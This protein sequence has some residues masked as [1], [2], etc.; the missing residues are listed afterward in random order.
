AAAG[1][2]NPLAGQAA[3]SGGDAGVVA[4]GKWGQSIVNLAPY[5]TAN[6]KVK[7]RF[8]MGSDGCGGNLGWFLDDVMVYRCVAP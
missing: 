4:S 3:F 1:N 8:E 7:L 2:T 6:D 5:A